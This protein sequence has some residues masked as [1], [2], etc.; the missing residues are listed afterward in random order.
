MEFGGCVC[1][2]PDYQFYFLLW[3]PARAQVT[4]CLLSLCHW[5]CTPYLAEYATNMSRNRR[6]YPV[7]ELAAGRTRWVRRALSSF[8]PTETN[9]Q[10]L[11]KS[12]PVDSDIGHFNPLGTNISSNQS[13]PVMSVLSTVLTS[14]AR[15]EV[16][17]APRWYSPRARALA[18]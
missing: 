10:N 7:D 15:S 8:S 4:P 13:V 16:S 2:V 1:A 17:A 11:R 9:S 18:L 6:T 12:C 3:F 14:R 5:F